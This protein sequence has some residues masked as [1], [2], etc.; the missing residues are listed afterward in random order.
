MKALGPGSHGRLVSGDSG[1]S[2]PDGKAVFVRITGRGK[3]GLNKIVV[4]P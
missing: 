1:K 2:V 3:C 4:R